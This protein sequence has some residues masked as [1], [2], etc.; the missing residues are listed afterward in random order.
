MT[1][2]LLVVDTSAVV[3]T[4]Q[5]SVTLSPPTSGI[6]QGI[7]YFQARNS[8]DETKVAGNGDYNVT[9]TFYVAGGLTD[10][11]GNGDA[12]IASQVVTLLMKAGG[13][14]ETN[15]VWA[16]PPTGRTRRLQLVE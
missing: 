16:G 11:Q 6:Y 4:G 10:L 8:P 7:S 5:G 14:G 1:P 15:I 9:G 2:E 12:S 3:I 13:N